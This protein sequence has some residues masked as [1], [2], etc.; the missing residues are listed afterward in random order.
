M[1]K[2]QRFGGFNMINVHNLN[3]S[4]KIKQVLRASASNHPVRYIQ[5]SAED[6]LSPFT[7]K[8]KLDKISSEAVDTINSYAFEIISNIKPTYVFDKSIDW[9]PRINCLDLLKYI[10]IAGFPQLYAQQLAKAGKNQIAQIYDITK[11]IG[12]PLKTQ[13]DH[14]MAGVNKKFPELASLLDKTY[15]TDFVSTINYLNNGLKIVKISS[16]ISS[17]DIR[18]V[19]DARKYKSNT[20]INIKLLPQVDKPTRLVSLATLSKITSV[21]H[22]NT[23]LRVLNGDIFCNE[24]LLKF[25]LTVTDKC[26]RCGMKET[27]VHILQECKYVNY[28]WENFAKILLKIGIRFNLT[29]E[30]ILNLGSFANNQAISTMVAEII[31]KITS[32]DRPKSICVETTIATL[33]RYE[34]NNAYLKK[35]WKNFNK[36]WKKFESLDLS[37]N[38]S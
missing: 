17:R 24:R 32:Y 15:H 11:I 2:P 12:H 30:N 29:L 6:L 25:G 5:C 1:L 22:K 28:I 19:L 4:L 10:K 38:E 33:L 21:K 8:G 14:V 27:S 23:M 37:G 7:N 13:A 36:F 26:Q 18:N 34:K 35:S 20:L 9:I 31:S 3:L 16:K